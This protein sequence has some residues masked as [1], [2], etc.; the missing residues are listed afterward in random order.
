MRRGL[1]SP[2]K[3]QLPEERT[4]LKDTG[5]FFWDSRFLVW[6]LFRPLARTWGSCFSQKK[7]KSIEGEKK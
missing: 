6:G 1:H 3:L 2:I 7:I 4:L 5:S